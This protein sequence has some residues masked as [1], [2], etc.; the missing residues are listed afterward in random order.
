MCDYDL[1]QCLVD[2][3]QSAHYYWW[4]KWMD[5]WAD[6]KTGDEKIDFL[7]AVRADNGKG[8]E[9]ILRKNGENV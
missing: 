8:L 4:D 7:K 5:K 6:S 9:T 1:T 2:G 3:K